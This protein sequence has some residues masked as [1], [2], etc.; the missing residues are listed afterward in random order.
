MNQKCYYIYINANKK[1]GA[2]YVGIT[3]KLLERIQQHKNKKD[4]KSFTARYNVDKLMYYEEY[5]DAR[6][7]IAREKQIKA[8][9]RKKKIEL[10]ESINPEWK[11]LFKEILR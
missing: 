6:T 2:L 3:S 9:S 11:D 10:I 5:P 8:G 4:K 7:A 1:N